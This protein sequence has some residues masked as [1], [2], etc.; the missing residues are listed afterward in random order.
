MV[1]VVVRSGKRRWKMMWVED[2][3]KGDLIWKVIK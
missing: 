2:D 1:G 3:G